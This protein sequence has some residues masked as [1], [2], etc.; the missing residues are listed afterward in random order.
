MSTTEP[1]VKSLGSLAPSTNTDKHSP[2]KVL[3]QANRAKMKRLSIDL[4]NADMKAFGADA[5]KNGMKM[6]KFFF[7]LWDQH[8]GK[9]RGDGIGGMLD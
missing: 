8:T 3:N 2:G 1:K 5:R 9:N 6:R 4:S 7:Y